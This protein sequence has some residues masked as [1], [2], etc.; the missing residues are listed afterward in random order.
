MT[1]FEQ[2]EKWGRLPKSKPLLAS[3]RERSDDDLI[4]GLAV[5]AA[6]ASDSFG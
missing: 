2:V 6:D 3:S 1:P 4:R 5:A